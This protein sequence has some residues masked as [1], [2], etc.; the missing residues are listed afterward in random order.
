MPKEKYEER[1]VH[2]PEDREVDALAARFEELLAAIGIQDWYADINYD[3][4]DDDQKAMV[5]GLNLREMFEHEATQET[6]DLQILRFALRRMA[7]LGSGDLVDVALQHL[8]ALHAVVPDLVRYLAQIRGMGPAERAD[9]G[10]RW[11]EAFR[12]SVLKELEYHRAWALHLFADGSDWN[13]EDAF[14]PLM[15]ELNDQFSRRKLTLAL[16]RA[17]A[18][19]WFQANRRNGLNQDFWSRR[20]FIAAASCMPADQRRHWFRSVAPGL[21]ILETAVME[22]AKAHPFA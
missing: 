18:S 13:N 1:F 22:W 21:D 20:A 8:D 7:Q 14:I 4:L 5:D 9:L 11:L 19:H 10:R 12:A 2:E 3:D 16:G 6:P 15:G 17:G